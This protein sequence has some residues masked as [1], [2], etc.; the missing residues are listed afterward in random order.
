MD[1]QI[2]QQLLLVLVTVAAWQ[3]D[4]ANVLLFPLMERNPNAIA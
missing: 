1:Q 2:T 3:Q 4:R